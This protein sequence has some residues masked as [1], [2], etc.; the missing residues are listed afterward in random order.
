MG[1]VSTMVWTNAGG[2]TGGAHRA[3][4]ST[5]HVAPP[6]RIVDIGRSVMST[7]CDVADTSGGAVDNGSDGGTGSVIIGRSWTGGG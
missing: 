2:T 6:Q 3:S 1:Y 4:S 5:Q 7:S